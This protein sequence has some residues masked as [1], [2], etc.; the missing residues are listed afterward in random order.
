MID[1][2]C[3]A[4]GRL[5]LPSCQLLILAFRNSPP[6]RP[7]IPPLPP[8]LSPGTPTLNQLGGL[9]SAVS[10]PWGEADIDIGIMQWR[11]QEFDLGVYVLTSHCNFKT[12]VN[13]HTRTK[14][15]LILGGFCPKCF[16]WELVEVGGSFRKGRNEPNFDYRFGGIETTGCGERGWAPKNRIPKNDNGCI[17][18]HSKLI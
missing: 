10:S 12:C 18:H 1:K 3:I 5:G 11:S 2:R 17:W 8:S 9:G 7:F 14:Q 15:L 16:W 6:L 13:V 4:G